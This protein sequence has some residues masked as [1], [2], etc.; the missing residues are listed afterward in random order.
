[1]LGE[2]QSQSKY[3]VEDKNL[4]AL[5]GIKAGFLDHPACSLVIRITG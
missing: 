4:L 5:L 1:M 2:L 3:F